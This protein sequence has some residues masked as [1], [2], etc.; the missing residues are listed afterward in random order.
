MSGAI[1][2]GMDIAQ[3][4]QLA[5]EMTR[6]ADEIRRLSQQITSKLHSTPWAGP[7]QQRFESDWTG[8]HTQQLNTV[9]QALQDAART[10]TQNAQEQESTSS[11]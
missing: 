7:D 9:V 8:Q 3:V 2:H 10:A 6:A 1:T 11:H 4:R 5:S